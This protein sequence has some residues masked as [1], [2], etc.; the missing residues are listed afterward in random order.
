MRTLSGFILVAL[1]FSALEAQ[2]IAGTYRQND[3]TGLGHA[4]EKDPENAGLRLRLTQA[5]LRR[6]RESAHPAKAQQRLDQAHAQ[7]QRILELNPRAIVP[8]RVLALDSYMGKRFEQTVDIGR[9]LLEIAPEEM[10]VTRILLK[11]LARLGRYE[12]G[13]DLFIQWLRSGTMP[14][15][16]SVAG[17]VSVLSINTKFRAA[18]DVR[19]TKAISERPRDVDLCLHHA[20]FLL[21][22]GRSESAW[23]AMHRGEALGLCDTRTGSRHAFARMM[24]SRA[25]EFTDSPSAVVGSDI[26]EMARYHEGHPKHAGLAMRYGRLLDLAGS[27]DRALV[28]YAKVC[29]L[30][31]GYWAAHY[32]TGKLLM[33]AGR[34]ADAASWFAKANALRPLHLPGR[35]SQ[36]VALIRAER[37]AEAVG[38]VM[39]GV[40][41]HAPGPS[42]RELLKLMK[43]KSALAELAKM[44]KESVRA[45]PDPFAQAH[46]ALT[47][48]V[49]GRG[50]E[51]RSVALAAERGG[52]GGIDGYPSI[53]LYEVFDEQHPSALSDK[54]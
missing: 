8:L 11:A 37:V 52:L 2:Q 19:F 27:R 39:Q 17:L 30:N 46:L 33:E 51:A 54:K 40:T 12:E 15:F 9:K 49:L 16:G 6:D 10:E 53:I 24:G 38:L 36:A 42:T 7:F 28:V 34:H 41:T 29:E 31:P 18:L 32:R 26:G 45:K 35:L 3:L 25:A 5:L 21:E 13:A 44:L 50:S 20:I 47:L 22:T 48:K 23:R 43:E 14:S 1:L 4:V